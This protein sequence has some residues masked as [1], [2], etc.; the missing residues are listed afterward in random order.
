[1]NVYK[2]FDKDLKCRGF[3]YELGKTYEEDSA[4]LCDCGF[5]AC[6]DPIDVFGYYP[7]AGSRYCEV[8]LEG[9]ADQKDN[10]DTKRCGSKITIGAEIGIP[11]IVKA[12]VEYVK[13][14]VKEKVEKGEAEAATAGSYGAA[15]AGSYGAAT[16]GYRGAATAGS[17]GAA[18]AGDSGA[19]TAGDSG[20]ATAGSYGA[21]TA[22]YSGAATA[23]SY[24]AATA[25]D[26][27]AATAGSYGAATAG[28]SGAATA[29]S[30]GAATSRGKSSV[31]K[32]GAA[33]ARGNNVKAMGGLGAIL[34]LVEEEADSYDI[35]HW[36]AVVVDG[37][38][39]KADTWY[40]LNDDGDVVEEG[41]A[42]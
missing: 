32:D 39:I 33:L 12:H 34:V 4:Y 24:G 29:G 5:H 22:G 11:G 10:S 41:G 2:G 27:G 23:G 6:E 16:A 8:E 20:A 40:T 28:D 36:K 38:T 30:Y 14:R 1:M 18:T 21:A 9:V 26:S 13:E 15:T 19:A 25:G 17:Y 37:E 31:G 3:Q 42:E 7:P 35:R